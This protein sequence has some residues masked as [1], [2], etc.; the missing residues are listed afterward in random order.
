V[1]KSLSVGQLQRLADVLTEVSFEDGELVV[2]QGQTDSTFYIISDGRTR[3]YKNESPSEIIMELTKGQY[4]NKPLL[5]PQYFGERSLLKHEPRAANVAAVGK[6]K[7]LYIAKD[8]FEEAIIDEDRNVREKLAASKQLQLESEGLSGV[9]FSSFLVK[10]QSVTNDGYTM[11][12]ASFK[13]REYT[14]KASSKRKVVAMSLQSRVMNEMVSIA[15]SLADLMQEIG[16]FEEKAVKFYVGCI[17]R[18]IVHLHGLDIVY[19]NIFPEALL[20]SSDGYIQLMD[21]SCAVKFEPEN[22]P[23]DYCGAAPYLSPEQCARCSLGAGVA[24]GPVSTC[25]RV[26]WEVS[27]METL[28]SGQGHDKAV[29][30][31][32]MGIVMHEMLLDKNPWLTG[33]DST[34]T[35]LGIYSRISSH[36]ELASTGLSPRCE[37]FLNGLLTNSAD[38]RL[39]VRGVGPEELR[40]AP[41]MA[42]LNFKALDEKSIAAPHAEIIA[43]MKLPPAALQDTYDGDQRWCESFNTFKH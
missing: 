2:R 33:D 16:P 34:D 5:T 41:W 26:G 29:D 25:W 12:L 6:L 17:A 15:C 10:G 38:E 27:S 36:R 20:L 40:A 37:E 42:D 22:K 8:A 35:E 7:C 13:D 28:V 19:R 9:E 30:Y 31:W 21:M 11:V 18:A 43:K 14:V 32:A 23:R 4:A 1:L 24:K 3:I 39:G